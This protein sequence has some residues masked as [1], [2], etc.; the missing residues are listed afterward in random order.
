MKLQL[1][2]RE[3]AILFPPKMIEKVGALLGRQRKKQKI[4]S[5]NQN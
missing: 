1:T 3:S 2:T 5:Y 4:N